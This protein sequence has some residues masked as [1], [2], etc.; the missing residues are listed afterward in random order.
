M[1]FRLSPEVSV[2]A[3]TPP[4]T[5]RSVLKLAAGASVSALAGCTTLQVTGNEPSGEDPTTAFELGAKSGGWVG[6]APSQIEGTRNP[7]LRMTPGT[8][9]EL[10]WENLDGEVHQFVIRDSLGETL[11]ES[12]TSAERGARRTVT[13]EADQAMTTYL[14]PRHEVIMRGEMLVTTH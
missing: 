11:V 13:F 7:I 9:I 4:P 6:L 14:D 5:R 10:T 2:M 3:R 12:R 1:L 8:S